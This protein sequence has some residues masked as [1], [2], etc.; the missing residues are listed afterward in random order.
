MK[1]H[2][3]FEGFDWD[4]LAARKIA[5]PRKP[6]DDAAK[7]IR[8]LA[9]RKGYSLAWNGLCVLSGWV[10][11]HGGV[12]ITDAA[13]MV[14]DCCLSLLLPLCRTQTWPPPLAA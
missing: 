6:R 10:Q 7:R 13:A 5:A 1:Q 8:E 12:S 2:K 4:A 14:H 3:W 9:V 11:V